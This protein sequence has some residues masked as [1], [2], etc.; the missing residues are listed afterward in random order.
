MTERSSEFASEVHW[1]HLKDRTDNHTMYPNS[2]AS[3]PELVNRE[4][5]VL[6]I[7]NLRVTNAFTRTLREQV[8]NPEDLAR[9][10]LR[11]TFKTLE[12]EFVRAGFLNIFKQPF[13][14]LDIV[15]SESYLQPWYEFQQSRTFA[16]YVE[17]LEKKVA[18]LTKRN[19]ELE[20]QISEQEA[21]LSQYES[22]E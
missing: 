9:G 1:V 3:M 4:R 21:H 6:H 17:I 22:F 13:P 7:K 19:A 15:P 14:E 20:C 11:D 5:L 2:G 12:S 8:R 16:D 10:V 18:Q